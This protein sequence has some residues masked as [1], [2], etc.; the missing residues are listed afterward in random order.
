MT[1]KPDQPRSPA[2]EA[3]Q[4]F[5]QSE[6]RCTVLYIFSSFFRFSVSAFSNRYEHV[7]FHKIIILTAPSVRAPGPNVS[8]LFL[9]ALVHPSL[10]AV[11]A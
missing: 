4:P 10:V 7:S 11:Q 3:Q 5:D 9:I 2:A 6:G 8:I 1:Q